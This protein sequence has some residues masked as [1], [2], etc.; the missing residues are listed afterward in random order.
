VVFDFAHGT[1]D[2]HPVFG[3]AVSAIERNLGRPSYVEHYARRIDLGYGLRARPRVEVIVNGT[4]WAIELESRADV[5]ARLGTLLDL[6]PESL[7]AR[8]AERYASVFKLA[9]SYHCDAKGCYGVFVD[10]GGNRRIIFGI[11]R[12]HRFVGLQLTHPP[13]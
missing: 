11:A 12:G 7:Q 9:R 1:V 2:G 13:K 6:T 5:E 10:R 4:A 3:Q 8:I